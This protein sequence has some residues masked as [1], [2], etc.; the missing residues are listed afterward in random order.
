MKVKESRDYYD[1][2]PESMLEIKLS[3]PDNFLK[4][5]ETLTRI[6]VASMKDNTLWQSCHILHK[7]G[8]YYIVHF[9]ELFCLDGKVST[10]TENDIERRNTITALLQEWGLLSIKDEEKSF[11]RAHLS[12]IKIVPYKEKEE[13]SLVAKYSIGIKTNKSA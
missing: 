6:G 4:V 13:W 11:P 5:K 8:N 2:S 7:R 10:L 3:E 9:L 1:W 12:Q